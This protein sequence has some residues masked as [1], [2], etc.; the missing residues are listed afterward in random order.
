[1]SETLAE[2]F[3]RSYCPPGGVVLDPFAGSGTTGA[4]AVRLGRR[5]LGCDVR[6]S[7]C[8]I[9]RKRIIRETPNLFVG[10]QEDHIP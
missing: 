10:T 6:E 5:F 9:A 3:V 8:E 4:V 1:M 2:F 7:Q